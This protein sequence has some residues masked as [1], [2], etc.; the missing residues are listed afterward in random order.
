MSMVK[1]DVTD[2]LVDLDKYIEDVE[3]AFRTGVR[4]FVMGVGSTLVEVT[5]VG[6]ADK[7]EKLYQQRYDSEGWEATEGMLLANWF[8][9]LNNPTSWFDDTARD[10]TGELLFSELSSL[11]QQYKIGDTINA[12]NSTP[13]V[14][15]IEAGQSKT[16][17]PSGLIKPIEDAIPEIYKIQVGD[18]LNG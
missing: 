14:S 15:A 7:Y 13:Y 6:D 11:M 10:T 18:M 16:Q 8:F 9:Q 3:S 1:P 4:R 2:T 17:A 12:N 5:P